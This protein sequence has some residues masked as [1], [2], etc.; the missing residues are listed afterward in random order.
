MDEKM[1]K[2]GGESKRRDLI[3][4]MEEMSLVDRTKMDDDEAFRAV[5]GDKNQAEKLLAQK[6]AR[7]KK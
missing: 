6:A 1:M 2:A 4:Q 5:G 3:S 7:G